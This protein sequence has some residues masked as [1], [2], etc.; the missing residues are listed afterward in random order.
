MVLPQPGE[1]RLGECDVADIDAFFT[2]LERQRRTVAAPDGG[3]MEK[4]RYAAATRRTIRS[5]VSG[6]PGGRCRRCARAGRGARAELA[7]LF[8]HPG[9][10]HL[11]TDSSPPSYDAETTALALQRPRELLNRSW[12]VVVTS[13]CSSWQSYS[14]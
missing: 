10:R 1:L 7:Q 9:D 3:F 13:S 5:V 14:H 12:P 4:P 8:V 11:F 2:R 6:V